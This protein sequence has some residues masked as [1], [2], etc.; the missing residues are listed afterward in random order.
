MTDAATAADEPA[1]HIRNAD[2]VNWVD[3][4]SAR[5]QREEGLTKAEIAERGGI[6]RQ[7][8]NL[9][10]GVGGPQSLPLAPNLIRFCVGNKLPLAEPYR[11]LGWGEPPRLSAADE[12]VEAA[13]IA[14]V[15]ALGDERLHAD[16]RA[17]ILAHL[18]LLVAQLRARAERR[19]DADS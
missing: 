2:F 19:R 6:S 3:R 15:D 4:V 14:V 1:G 10:R 7:Q 5:I 13:L 12:E 17:E 16:D 9:W 18:D 8:Y 11:V